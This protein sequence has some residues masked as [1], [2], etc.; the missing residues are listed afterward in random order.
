MYN[1]PTAIKM[2]AQR[3]IAELG[4]TEMYDLGVSERNVHNL[5]RGVLRPADNYSEATQRRIIEEVITAL[6]RPIP[7][8]QVRSR[9]I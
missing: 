5:V 6:R 9:H 2:L 4:W 1:D 3:V 7:R 8:S